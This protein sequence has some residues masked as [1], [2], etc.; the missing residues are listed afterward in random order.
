VGD[1]Q[2]RKIG[3]RDFSMFAE[4]GCGNE[5]FTDDGGEVFF[6]D[7]ETDDLV[8]LSDSVVTF[9]SSLVAPPEV[10]LKP[11]QVKRVWAD[12]NFNPRFD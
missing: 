12:P 9:L 7:H 6:W 2:K 4:D 5:F 8:P 3:E 1:W 10:H 11:A